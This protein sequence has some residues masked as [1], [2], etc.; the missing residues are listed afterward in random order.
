MVNRSAR[1]GLIYAALENDVTGIERHFTAGDDPDSADK[2]EGFYPLHFA[3]RQQAVGAAKALQEAGA[4]VI[5]G[6]GTARRLPD[7][8]GVLHRG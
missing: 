2:R 1:S 7:E 8:A 6:T 5:A 3:A 4:D